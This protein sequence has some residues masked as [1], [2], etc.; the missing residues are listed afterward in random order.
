MNTQN[1]I[2]IAVLLGLSVVF[3]YL[4]FTSGSGKIRLG[5]AGALVLAAIILLVP[6]FNLALP[7]WA[8]PLDRLPKIQLGLDLQ[9]GTHLLLEVQINEAVK[10]ALRRRGDDMRTELKKNK[11]D[12]QSVSI[13]KDGALQV[14]LKS[15]SQSSAFIN[16]ATS[17]AFS[18]L[19][20]ARGS[21]AGAG[22]S[23]VFTYK[24]QELTQVKNNAMDQAL[25]T[26]RN[27]IDQ[28][29]VRETTVVKEGDTDILVQLPGIQDPEQAKELIGKTAV[30]EF[31]LLDD[32][33]NVADALHNAPPP[34]DQLLYG[35]PQPGGSEPYL[36]QTPVLM[37]GDVVTDARVR[38]GA[39]LEGPYVTVDLDRRGTEIFAALTTQNVG[40]H[41][42]IILDNTVYSAP[43]IKEPIPGGHVQITGD[44]SFDEAHQ[45][46]IVLR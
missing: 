34:G 7:E 15:P 38:P 3:L 35:Q 42:A 25:E 28:L 22:P 30:L 21:S 13:N 9:G 41:L 45:L 40:R 17:N 20:S 46:A 1:P 33:H 11:I 37:T 10:T 43:V 23:Y 14:Q 19:T 24:P 8:Q 6:S 36:V 31:K 5:L 2:P 39:S 18:D 12:V 32:S 27:R 26:I 29:G 44:F 4:H 16:I